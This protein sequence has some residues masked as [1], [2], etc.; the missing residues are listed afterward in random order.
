LFTYYLLEGL[1]GKAINSDGCVTPEL[2]GKY[3]YDKIMSLPVELRSSQ[4][5]ITKVEQS[6]DIIL[7]CYP[8]LATKKMIYNQPTSVEDLIYKT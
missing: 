5:P 7:A 2:L 1:A 8:R 3:I 4:R 6:G